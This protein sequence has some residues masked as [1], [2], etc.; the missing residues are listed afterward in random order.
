MTVAPMSKPLIRQLGPLNAWLQSTDGKGFGIAFFRSAEEA[1]RQFS[2]DTDKLSMEGVEVVSERVWV[3]TRDGMLR[4]RAAPSEQDREIPLR[5]FWN[6]LLRRK[7]RWR[8]VYNYA[9]QNLSWLDD[10]QG[11]LTS[12]ERQYLITRL[13]SVDSLPLWLNRRRFDFEVWKSLDYGFGRRS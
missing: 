1:V 3:K 8:G 5:G 4:Y 6:R 7:S 2:L 10:P 13:R 11:V 12:E 9:A